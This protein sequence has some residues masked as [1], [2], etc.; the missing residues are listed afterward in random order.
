MD[1]RSDPV[2]A[3][4]ILQARHDKIVHDFMHGD[5][6]IVLERRLRNIGFAGANLKTEVAE[7]VTARAALPPGELEKRKRLREGEK[8]WT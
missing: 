4:E 8:A 7:H 6:I 2:E 5:S 1:T 3:K